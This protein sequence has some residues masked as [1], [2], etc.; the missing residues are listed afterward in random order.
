MERGFAEGA[1][2]GWFTSEIEPAFEQLRNNA[3]FSRF[4]HRAR[5]HA[6]AE[7][8]RVEELRSKGSVP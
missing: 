3:K 2:Q 7:D 1:F 5:V 6:A 8:M 4:L